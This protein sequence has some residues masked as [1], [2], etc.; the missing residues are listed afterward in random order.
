[1]RFVLSFPVPQLISV[2]SLFSK[3]DLIRLVTASPMRFQRARAG[4]IATYADD[5]N[6]STILNSESVVLCYMTSKIISSVS[7]FVI[8][9]F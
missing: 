4:G 6:L 5:N 2:R 7:K 9:Q 8:Y 3:I 1:M